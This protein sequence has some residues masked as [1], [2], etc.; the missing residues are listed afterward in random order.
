MQQHG[1]QKNSAIMLVVVIIMLAQ[2]GGA[3]LIPS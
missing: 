3:T 1:L 2:R